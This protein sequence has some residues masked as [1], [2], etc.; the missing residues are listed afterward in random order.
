VKNVR[1]FRPK[2]L[3][4]RS[5]STARREQALT[6]IKLRVAHDKDSS[7]DCR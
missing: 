3:A 1:F 7:I 2:E 5:R 4:I 6:Q